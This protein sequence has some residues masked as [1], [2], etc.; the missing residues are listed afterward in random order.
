MFGDS[1]T[2]I[3]S[4]E[5]LVEFAAGMDYRKRFE[6]NKA[7]KEKLSLYSYNASLSRMLKVLGIE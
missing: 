1:Y 5:N 7:A 4:I 6:L 3:S 2:Y